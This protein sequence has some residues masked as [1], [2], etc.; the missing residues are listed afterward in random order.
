MKKFLLSVATILTVGVAS[1]QTAAEVNTKFNEAAALLNAKNYS[2]AIPVL[3][4]TIKMAQSATEDVSSTLSESQKYLINAYIAD[5][6]VTASKGNFDKSLEDFQK[7]Y[8]LSSLTSNI[9]GKKNAETMLVAVHSA[10]GGKYLKAGDNAAALESYEKAVAISPKNTKV[11]LT[12]A[13]LSAK[14]GDLEKAGTYYETIINLGDS[15]SKY[16]ADAEKAKAAYTIDLMN[17]AATATDFE[18]AE[19]SINKVLSFDPT[20]AVALSTLVKSANNYKKY[21]VV[22]ANADNAI[23]AQTEDAEK[24]NLNFLA[25]VAYEVKENTTKALSHYKQV[26]AGDNVAAAKTQVT[27]LSK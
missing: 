11:L 20:S 12:A 19:A 27:A 15:H 17:I 3:E 14:N 8:D 9:S 26:T 1:A 21:D 7:A 16:Q 2:G 6:K 5:G 10:Q 22:I 4:E 18:T 25:G 13:Q 23:A 24:G